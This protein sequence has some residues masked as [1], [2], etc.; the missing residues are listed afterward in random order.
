MHCWT[1]ISANNVR[2]FVFPHFD[3]LKLFYHPASAKALSRRIYMN[4]RQLQ[5]GRS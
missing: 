4:R 3:A 2:T 5:P 1:N